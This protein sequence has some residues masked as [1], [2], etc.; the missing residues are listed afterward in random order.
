VRLLKYNQGEAQPC[1]PK[2]NI[3]EHTYQTDTFCITWLWPQGLYP[4]TKLILNENR[5]VTI[6]PVPV[7]H[8]G[9]PQQQLFFNN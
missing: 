1:I 2:P 9:D 3:K 8:T 4:E 6:V 5:S 7:T